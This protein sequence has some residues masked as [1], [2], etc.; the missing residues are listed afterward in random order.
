MFLT[1]LERCIE[2]TQLLS[3]LLLS[4]VTSFLEKRSLLRI[5]FRRDVYYMFTSEPVHNFLWGMPQVVKNCFWSI[6]LL[7]RCLKANDRWYDLAS[8]FSLE[9]PLFFV[10]AKL[11]FCR[12][13]RSSTKRGWVLTFSKLIL[14]LSLAGCSVESAS[15]AWRKGN[16]SNIYRLSFLCRVCRKS[17]RIRDWA[18]LDKVQYVTLWVGCQFM[19]WQESG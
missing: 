11:F 15:L 13:N 5:L 9:T 12:R 7:G 10:H 17:T 3:N 1:G 14:S 8:G 6:F 16:I 19:F 18:N 4:S 2:L